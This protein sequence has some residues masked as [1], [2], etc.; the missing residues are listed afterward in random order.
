VIRE[1]P[2]LDSKAGYISIGQ[3]E[4]L[5]EES[6][7]LIDPG[8]PDGLRPGICRFIHVDLARQTLSAY[9]N[10]RIVF[11]TLVSSGQEDLH[12]SPGEYAVI[13]KMEYRT[14]DSIPGARDK[15]YL[16]NV[17]Y[18]MTYFGNL[19]IHGVYWHD[20]FGSPVS[21]G[22]I[23]LSVT[24]ARWLYDWVILGNVLLITDGE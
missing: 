6:A 2:S 5:P 22:C 8:L 11:A 7:T 12:T 10:C 1:F 16:E 24:D 20:Q 23:N 14:L 19:G 21:H 15:Y 4:W 3:N 17:P 13:H 9:D 18:F